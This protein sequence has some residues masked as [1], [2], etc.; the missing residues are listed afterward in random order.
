MADSDKL[1]LGLDDIIRSD[2]NMKRRGGRGG[3]RRFQTRGGG[4]PGGVSNGFRARGGG[5]L[6]RTS[7]TPAGRWKHDLYDD[8]SV[9]ARVGQRNTGVNSTTKLLVSNLDYGVTTAD[10]QELFGDIGAV[11]SASV[12]FDQSGRSL[13][14]AEIVFERRADAISA[15]QKY[16][17]LNLDGRPMDIKVLGGAE[18][19]PARTFNRGPIT[20][21]AGD[22]NQRSGPRNFRQQNG[23]RGGLNRPRGGGTKKETVTAEDLDADLEAYRAQST[24]KK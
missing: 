8:N 1:A 9:Q 3:N 4:R 6:P 5:G 7:N 18:G 23:N 10:I 17:G 21:G 11:R 24:Q 13:G 12:H 14:T 22:T 16:D 19:G 15:K 20:N 2:P